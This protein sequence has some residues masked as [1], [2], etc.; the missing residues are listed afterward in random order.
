LTSIP[1]QMRRTGRDRRENDNP[2]VVS[3]QTSR[4]RQT[5]DRA[6]EGGATLAIIDT[7]GKSDSAATETARCQAKR[8]ATAQELLAEALNDLFAKYNVP[9]VSE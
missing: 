3:A 4:L 8:P 6:R 5:L 9:T 7:P 2:A 1:R